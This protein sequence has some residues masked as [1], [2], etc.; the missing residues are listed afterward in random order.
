MN[1]GRFLTCPNCGANITNTQNC[2]YCGSLLVRFVDRGIDLAKTTYL[3]NSCVSNKL[4]KALQLCLQMQEQS[5]EDVVLDM[6]KGETFIDVGC[7]LQSGK[8]AFSD[9]T[10]IP[11]NTNKGL[12][13]I[14]SFGEKDKELLVKFQAL[15][16]FPLFTGRSCLINKSIWGGADN[17][18]EYYI[19]FGNDAEGAA[20]IMSDVISKVYGA[21]DNDIEC[22]V[23]TGNNIAV[24][25]DYYRTKMEQKRDARSTAIWLLVLLIGFFIFIAIVTI[26]DN[27][28]HPHY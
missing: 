3:D 13:I 22:N 9:G 14:W 24:S 4:L 16:C 11:S 5:Q 25:R 28:Y 2:E 12:C 20:R 8:C 15:D 23:N 17:L 6:Y 18:I 10:L 1:E 19:D 7:V 26:I 27:S 21:S